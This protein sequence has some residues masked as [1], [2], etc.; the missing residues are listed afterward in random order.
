M[1]AEN[2]VEPPPQWRFHP[3][4]NEAAAH[5]RGKLRRRPGPRPAGAASM[6]PRRMAAENQQNAVTIQSTT[7]CFNE[8]AAHGR[9]KPVA[10]RLPA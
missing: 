5:G 9:G 1:A 6:R 2:P 10:S 7:R 4:F 3:G 8:A